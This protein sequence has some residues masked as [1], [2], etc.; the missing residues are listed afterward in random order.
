MRRRHPKGQ[1]LAFTIV[2]NNGSPA[3]TAEDRAFASDAR[4]A[5]IDITLVGRSLSFILQNYYDLAAPANINKWEAEDFGGY[6]SPLYPTT[7]TIFN[8]GGDFNIGD[9]SD[10]TADKLINNSVSGPS[11]SAIKAEATYIAADLP[12]L[13][14]PA[15][16][17]VYAWSTSL[18]GPQASFWEM[19]QYSLNPELW[20]FHR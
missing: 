1:R 13:F 7:T 18:S 17:H 19:T 15:P 10:R 20:A 12:G 5:G 9:Y 16:D 6:S 14:Q 11:P 4:R 2:Y 8:T 3:I